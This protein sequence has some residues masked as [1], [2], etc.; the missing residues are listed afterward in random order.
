MGVSL[1]ARIAQTFAIEHPERTMTLTSIMSSPDLMAFSEAS[2][3]AIALLFTPRPTDDSAAREAALHSGRVLAGEFFDERAVLGY[4]RAASARGGAYPMGTARQ[5]CAIFASG[6][7]E[8]ALR[9]LKVPTLVIH[10]EADPLIPP[11]ARP[12]H[13]RADP[14]CRASDGGEDGPRPADAALA[15]AH[16]QD[17]GVRAEYTLSTQYSYQYSIPNTH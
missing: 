11:S 17:R 9:Q 16:R 4:E 3:E 15:A 12:A 6:A 5:M 13:R 1:G 7:R 8:E 10:G 2:P 14:R